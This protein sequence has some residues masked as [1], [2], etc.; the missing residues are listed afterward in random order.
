MDLDAPQT[1]YEPADPALRRFTQ[2]AS[3]IDVNI[4]QPHLQDSWRIL[5]TVTL[6]AGLKSSLQFA[7]GIVP[8]QPLPGSL[9]GSSTALPQGE[10]DTLVGFLPDFGATW[11]ATAH[12]EFFANIQ[13]NVRQFQNYVSGLS[14]FSLGSQAAFEEF[15]QNTQPETSWTYEVGLRSHR[16]VSFGPLSG[17]E[18]Q[19]NYYHVD[20]SNRLLQISPTPVITSIVGGVPL[21]ENV[22]SVTTDGVDLA[23]TLHFGPHLSFYD[24]VS[25]NKSQYDDNY[26]NGT[27]TVMTAARTSR[28]VPTG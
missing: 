7:S 6:Q 23:G 1:P 10:I 13:K 26:V 21:I 19:V 17:V 22:G 11:Q 2:Y 16:A 12:E 5:P 18:G 28:P 8:V 20:F 4:V 14:A 9:A 3:E 25:Y 15:K 27:A 24:A